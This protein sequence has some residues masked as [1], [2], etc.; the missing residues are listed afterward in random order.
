M[1][2][3]DAIIIT[4]GEKGVI[5]TIH[6]KKNISNKVFFE[7]FDDEVRSSLS[8]I[9]AENKTQN[10]YILFDTLDQNFKKKDYPLMKKTDLRLLIKRE[11]NSGPNKNSLKNFLILNSAGN[12]SGIKSWQVIFISTSISSKTKDFFNFIHSLP[13]R[14]IGV[15]LSSIECSS[16]LNHIEKFYNKKLDNEPKIN[17]LVT[18]TKISGIRQTIYYEKQILFTRLLDYK[19][20]DN[21]FLKRYEKDLYASYEYLHRIF[22]AISLKNF[23]I[24]NIMPTEAIDII[25]K[26]KNIEFN[27]DNFTPFKIAKFLNKNFEIKEGAKNCDLI[28]SRSFFQQK[29][30]THLK[31]TT[32]QIDNE[33]KLYFLMRYSY[34]A[35]LLILLSIG[36]LSLGSISKISESEEMVDIAKIKH[37]NTMNEVSHSKKKLLNKEIELQRKYGEEARGIK[38]VEIGQIN[39]IFNAK[40]AILFEEFSKL[41][42][43]KNYNLKVKNFSYHVKSFNSTKVNNANYGLAIDARI[44]NKS[45]DVDDLFTKYDKL[46]T[47]FKQNYPKYKISITELPKNI[48]LSEKYYYFDIKINI[49]SK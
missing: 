26:M 9:L 15:Y 37:L 43:I 3:K 29:S 45:G 6:N 1:K 46:G 35:S 16:I 48:N 5:F 4:I 39:E 40:E 10:I 42:F 2:E 49:S 18:Q 17:C 13:N 14:L 33:K 20:S 23:C 38:I 8:K 47:N 12:N 31:F 21:D 34:F 25:S 7:N 11:M 30:S 27:I 32:Q 24:T 19:T 44:I 28:I 22:P 36:V 41:N